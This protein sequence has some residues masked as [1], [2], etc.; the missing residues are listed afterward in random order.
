[1]TLVYAGDA[2][3]TWAIRCSKL[4]RLPVWICAGRATGMLAGSCAGYGMPRPA[5][6]NGGNI[7]LTEDV[8]KGVEGLTLSIPMYGCRWGKQKRNGRTDCITA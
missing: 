6:Q 5:Q 8:A 2:V 1:M 3:T 7:T 4:R